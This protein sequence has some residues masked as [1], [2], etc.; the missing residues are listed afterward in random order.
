MIGDDAV[1]GNHLAHVRIVTGIQGDGSIKG[2]KVIEIDPASGEIEE[3]FEAFLDSLVAK[4]A[5]ELGFG[6]FYF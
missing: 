3:P 6:I 2:T 5:V 4:D 1:P